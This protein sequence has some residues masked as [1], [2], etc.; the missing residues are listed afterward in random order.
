MA[1][2]GTPRAVVDEI[3]AAI[4]DAMA[5]PDMKEKMTGFGFYPSAG[6]AKQ[7]ADLTLADRAKYAEILKKVKVEVD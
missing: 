1:P 7:V 2:A 4:N 3:N 5:Q 6:P